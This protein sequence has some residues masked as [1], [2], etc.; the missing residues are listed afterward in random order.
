MDRICRTPTGKLSA[1]Q[2]QT[3]NTQQLEITLPIRN[4]RSRPHSR[5]CRIPRARWWFSQMRRVVD[6]AM[7]WT[8]A[9]SARPEQ[10]HLPLAQG[11]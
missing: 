5:P 7:E 1:K 6:D 9:N 11:R 3:M 8:P 2:M 10:T 4:R